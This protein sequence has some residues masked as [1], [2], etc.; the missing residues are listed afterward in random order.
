[1]ISSLF[2]L[3]ST[4]KIIIE[5]HWRG[6]GSRS[7]VDYFL[8][9]TKGMP[10]EEVLPLI[11]TPQGNYVQIYRDSLTF[12]TTV[13]AEVEPLL[14]LE[15]LHRVV[16]LL[17][18]Y[19]SEV[20]ESIIKDNFVTVYQLLEEMMDYGY[21]L[22]TEPNALKDIILPPT[23]IN[24]VMSA[25]GVTADR[26]PNGTLS[27]VPWRKSGVKYTNNE[28][29][30]DIVEELD[31]I[32]DSNGSTISCEINGT[33][34][35]NSRLSGMPD[36]TLSFVNPRIFDDYSL[37]PCVRHSKY[38]NERV[39]SFIPPDG[40]FKLMSYRVDLRNPTYLPI[41]V[42]P[43]ISI[44]NNGGKFDISVS[45]RHSDGKPVENLAIT[46]PMAQSIENVSASPNIGQYTF[47][48]ATKVLRWDIGRVQMK[49]RMPMIS[50]TF[51]A[52]EKLS[53]AGSSILADFQINMYAISGLK[54]DSLRVFYEGYKPYKGVRSVTKSGKFQIRI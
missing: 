44:Y 49:D 47:D 40:Q 35:S 18:E 30:F 29:Y 52:S 12:L 5:K 13:S 2:V 16:D 37:H 17:V 28:I 20:S 45:I 19:F 43:Q 11:D 23:I 9:V 7:V 25:A 54:V 51:T 41:Y 36:L 50:G 31:T 21:P 6:V 53:S 8:N 27:N 15:F 46:F 24:R 22:T 3:N 48:R 38:E 42:K 4:G 26:L 34:V 1:M 32:V 33:I 14:V 10:Q 39:L